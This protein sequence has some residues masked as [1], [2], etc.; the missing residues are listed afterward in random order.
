LKFYVQLFLISVVVLKLLLISTYFFHNQSFPILT[1]SVAMA[2]EPGDAGSEA[3]SPSDGVT[4][5]GESGLLDVS[6]TGDISDASQKQWKEKH[7]LI[8]EKEKFLIRREEQLLA[9]QEEIN[10]K[11]EE[12]THL[13]NEIRD[14][15]D[16][17][18]I[19][20]ENQVKHLIKIYSTMK[21][22]KVAEMIKE[23]D[24]N[25][26]TEL[27]SRMKGDSVGKILSFVDPTI[28]AKITQSLFPED[29]E[30][31]KSLKGS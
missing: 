19:A 3:S 18:K 27:F 8:E 11:I 1:T 10:K 15:F 7:T 17:K 22:Q 6:K 25:L 31:N 12:L 16:K 30:K 9:L 21:P 20:Q 23:L 2:L 5:A 4:S 26:V 28:G 24:I 29:M 14:E 13:R